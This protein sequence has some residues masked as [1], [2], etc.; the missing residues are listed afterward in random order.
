MAAKKKDGRPT[1]YRK[2]MG[3]EICD[4]IALGDNLNTISLK[5]EYPS[6]V[7]LYKWLR[8]HEDFLNNYARAR[9]ARADARSDRIDEI[10]KKVE[11]KTMDPQAARV[12]IDAEKWQAGKERPKR[13][14]DRV[15]NVH[16][17]VDDSPIDHKVTVE[18]VNAKANP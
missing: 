11:N 7:T 13:Y 9:E 14:G 15:H 4:L 3:E 18:F 1:S 5:D 12:I 16:A 6:R 8:D 17:G 10:C 2:E